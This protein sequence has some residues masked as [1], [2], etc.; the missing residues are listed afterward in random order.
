MDDPFL[1]QIVWSGLAFIVLVGAAP[2]ASLCK[3]T[4]PLNELRARG[5]LAEAFPHRT[6][7]S[8]WLGADGK[9]ALA[10]SGA[11]AL[12]VCAVGEGFVVRQIPW[13]QALSRSFRSGSIKIDLSDDAA[14]PA[15][16]SLIAWPPKNLAA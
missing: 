14:P 16:I 10:K 15:L 3:P 7:E 13:A 5:L 4:G 12:I 1:E 9:A 6:V 8:V 11:L 2:W